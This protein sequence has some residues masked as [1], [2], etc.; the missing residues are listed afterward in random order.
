MYMLFVARVQRACAGLNPACG[1]G[2]TSKSNVSVW[3]VP[4]D[5]L[6]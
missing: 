4:L 2:N 5:D 3:L 1:H 6:A